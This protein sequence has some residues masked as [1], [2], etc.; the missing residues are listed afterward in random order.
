MSTLLP[1]NSPRGTPLA[2]KLAINA[3][4]FSNIIAVQAKVSTVGLFCPLNPKALIIIVITN[5]IFHSCHW[6]C[7][8]GQVISLEIIIIID[9]N[10]VN[11][12][13]DFKLHRTNANG[14]LVSSGWREV[15]SEN[16]EGEDK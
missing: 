16:V 13:T 1:E 15:Q 2:I 10:K 8:I 11:N 9:Q 14:D 6:P 7:S 3:I 4:L 5:L 12:G